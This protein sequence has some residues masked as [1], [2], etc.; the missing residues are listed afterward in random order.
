MNIE[1]LKKQI[2][3]DVK[4][5]YSTDFEVI[6]KDTD[7]VPY[8]DHP[9]LT[10]PDLKNKQVKCLRL[11]T[12]VLFIDI[13]K[14]TEL[15]LTKRPVTLSKLYSSFISSMARIAHYFNGKVRNIVGDRLMVV[16]DKEL[17]FRNAVKTAIGMYSVVEYVLNKHFSYSD[18]QCGIGIDYGKML[19]AKTGVI[20]HR[21]ENQENKAL[22]WLGRP[23]NIASKLTDLANKSNKIGDTEPVILM[24]KPV[25]DG[26]KKECP[27]CESVKNDWWKKRYF[28]DFDYDQEIYGGSIYFKIFGE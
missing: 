21:E 14:S 24:T 11:E 7:Q 23:A 6:I 3:D 16:Y 17:C 27:E 8:V 13:R 5:I 9:D 26:Y 12:C 28:L 18:V 25:L 19:I 4:T 10:F 15:N 22:V 20:K 1:D 2:E